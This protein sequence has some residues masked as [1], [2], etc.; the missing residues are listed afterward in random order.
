MIDIRDYD[1]ALLLRFQHYYANTHWINKPAFQTTEIY[2]NQLFDGKKVEFPLLTLRR[3]AGPYIYKETNGWSQSR[4]GLYDQKSD[5]E[6]VA[7]NYQLTYELDVLSYDRDNY[8]ELMVEVQEN[9]I[10]HPYLSFDSDDKLITGVSVHLDFSE[11]IDNSDLESFQDKNPLYRATLTLEL[12]AYIYRK[13]RAVTIEQIPLSYK[14][15]DYDSDLV[16][17]IKDSAGQNEYITKYRA[18]E[19][20]QLFLYDNAGDLSVSYLGNLVPVSDLYSKYGLTDYSCVPWGVSSGE[21]WSWYDTRTEL[22]WDGRPGRERWLEEPT[23]W[24]QTVEFRNSEYPQ[25]S[26]ILPSKIEVPL[27]H[28]IRLPIVD[29]W[30]KDDHFIY[31]PVRWT[32]GEFSTEFTVWESVIA[33]LVWS[34]SEVVSI[35]FKNT[36]FPMAIIELPSSV[37]ISK[38]SSFQLPEIVG[39]YTDSSKYYRTSSWSIGKFLE[40]IVVDQDLVAD[41]VWEEVPSKPVIYPQGQFISGEMQYSDKYVVLDCVETVELDKGEIMTLSGY[42]IYC[43][44]FDFVP[45]EG[46]DLTL[47]CSSQSMSVYD[48]SEV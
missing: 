33:E 42:D 30:H 40:T 34:K 17:P 36:R 21:L 35:E 3:I 28:S 23:T 25:F 22:Y 29:Y 7:S 44:S 38:G 37:V 31:L 12:R 45:D 26:V 6:F 13:Y 48:A 5:V 1:Q 2:D 11:V 9:L 20:L 10:R 47:S 14:I 39:L 4:S 8:D 19:L 18:S 43:S 16:T 32:I 41:L 27:G 15:H 46:L 24:F